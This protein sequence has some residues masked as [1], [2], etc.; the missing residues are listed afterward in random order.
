VIKLAFVGDRYKEA[1]G[2]NEGALSG[3]S[4]EA[5]ASSIGQLNGHDVQVVVCDLRDLGRSPSNALRALLERPG[6]ELAVVT[7]SFA[8]RQTLESLRIDPRVRVVQGPISLANLRA[9]MV[10]LIVRDILDEDGRAST[11]PHPSKC[12]QCGAS[13]SV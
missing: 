1:V 2:A 8:P 12:P 13:L 5:Y 4:V 7:F 10:H 6:L 3:V 11:P 9:Q